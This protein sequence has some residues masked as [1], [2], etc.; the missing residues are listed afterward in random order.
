M[1]SSRFEVG[2]A[3]SA[4]EPARPGVGGRRVGGVPLGGVRVARWGRRRLKLAS[5]TRTTLSLLLGLSLWLGAPEGSAQPR[6]ASPSAP[7]PADRPAAKP[8]PQVQASCTKGS[9]PALTELACELGR[10]LASFGGDALVIPAPLASDVTVSAPQKVTTQLASLVAG[11]LGP[12][13]R[14]VAEAMPVSR[15]RALSGARFLIVLEPAIRDDTL[16]VTANVYH[17]G[18]KFWQRVRGPE[19]GAV[20]HGYAARPLDPELRALLPPLPLVVSRIDKARLP[21]PDPVALAC[22]DVDGD[23]WQ[24]I[25]FVGR[26]RIVV[27]RVRGAALVAEQSTKWADLSPVAGAPLREPIAS[28]FV[29]DAGLHIGLT[30]RA[31]GLGFGAALGASATRFPGFLPWPGGGCA[32]RAEL[33][34]AGR[35]RACT[36]KEPAPPL[37]DFGGPL[38]AIGGAR[39]VGRDGKQKIFHAGRL[40]QTDTLVVIEQGRRTELPGSGAKLAIGDLDGDGD[41]EIATSANT[42]N[43]AEDAVTVRTWRADGK[44]LERFKLPVPSGVQ[45]LAVCSS[46]EQSGFLPLIVAAGDGLW[47][48]R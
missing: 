12:S 14:A 38:D 31:D 15:A 16:S 4:A 27:G 42:A 8:A 7:R 35:V 9:A 40:W 34:L 26:R 29:S 5:L 37:V 21:D 39:L 33:G 24:E 13:V 18:A 25:A 43:A 10:Q 1:L 44:I 48:V 17:A 11:A 22:G 6:P 45:A 47:V 20:G 2:G 28:A 41:P 3:S 36:A 30:D 23:G 46:R 32:E 19:S